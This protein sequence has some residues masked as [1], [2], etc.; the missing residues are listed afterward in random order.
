VAAVSLWARGIIMTENIFQIGGQASARS[1]IGRKKIVRA[2]QRQIIDSSGNAAISIVGL[3]RVG[4]SSLI[5]NVLDEVK[6]REKGYL[7]IKIVLADSENYIAFWKEIIVSI[8]NEMIYYNI[9]DRNIDRAI[10]AIRKSPND[11]DGYT[12]CRSPIKEVFKKLRVLGRTIIMVIDEFDRA[13]TI[14]EGKTHY[15]DFLRTICSDGDYSV[16]TILISRRSIN[17]IENCTHQNS[18]FHGIFQNNTLTGFNDEDLLDYYGALDMYGVSLTDNQKDRL[19]YYCGRLPYLLSIFGF[20]IVEGRLNGEVETDID[21]I[22]NANSNSII[23]YYSDIKRQLENDNHIEKLLGFILGPKLYIAKN[24]EIVL[25]SLGLLENYGDRYYAIC[26][27]FNDYI[28][29]LNLSFPI[30]DSI[31]N[32]EKTLKHLIDYVMSKIMNSINW[33]TAFKSRLDSDDR[34]AKSFSIRVKDIDRVIGSSQRNFSQNQTLLDSLTM[35]NITK[36]ILYQDYWNHSDGFNRYFNGDS[37]AQW[38]NKIDM[39][40]RARNAVAHGHEEYLT[41]MQTREVNLYCEEI[42]KCVNAALSLC[43]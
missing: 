20:Y 28:A 39:C 23:Q 16:K 31:M 6:I 14:F 12:V 43:L 40:A 27:H 1:F 37:V 2:F 29:S 25:R 30:W 7:Y 8:Q 41:E 10:S 34:L 9:Q 4:K 24:D 13:Q 38:K 18:S 15:F 3:T 33:Q 32:T 22:F 11:N 36:I 19:R 21:Q 42:T 26:P 35:T 17:I 5:L